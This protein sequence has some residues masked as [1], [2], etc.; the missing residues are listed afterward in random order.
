MSWGHIGTTATRNWLSSLGL[1]LTSNTEFVLLV[2]MRHFAVIFGPGLVNLSDLD[3]PGSG[4]LKELK[5]AAPG[6]AVKTK[7]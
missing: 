3:W 6:L 7:D 4:A 5:Q 1:P 2:L